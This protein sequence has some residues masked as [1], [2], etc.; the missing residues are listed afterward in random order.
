MRHTSVVTGM[1][2]LHVPLLCLQVD[3]GYEAAGSDAVMLLEHCG[4]PLPAGS[5]AVCCPEEELD[6]ALQVLVQQ[7][8]C[9]V[10]SAAPSSCL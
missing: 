7:L 4:L 8:G 9:E 6:D 3:E 1:R 5:L 2:R 10:V